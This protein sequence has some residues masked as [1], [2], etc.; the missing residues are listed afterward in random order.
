MAKSCAVI[1]AAGEGKRMKSDRPKVML[2]VLFKPMIQ[3]V[4]DSVRNSGTEDICTVVGFK[5]EIIK[6]YLGEKFT[7]VSQ[8]ERLGT[9]HAV[10]Q[11]K[12]FLADHAG[13]HV[14][15][16]C[17]DAP[18]MDSETIRVAYE[19]HISQGNAATI[20]TACLDDPTGYGRVIR[21]GI[22]GPVQRIVEHKDATDE[23]K[24]VNEINS[25]AYW[26]DID[27]LLPIL[28]IEHLHNNNAQGEYYLPEVISIFIEKK[29]RV[30]AYLTENKEAVMGANDCLQLNDLSSKARRNILEK[31]LVNGVEM[32]CSEGVIIGPD[33][34]IGSN[35]TILPGTILKG[36]TVVGHGCTVGPNS[37][38]DDCTVGDNSKVN[39]SQC[40]GSNIGNN[41]DIGPF[42]H[43]RNGCVVGD[44]VRIGDY[45]E[46]KNS[47]IGNE[48]KVAHLT[49][50]GDSKFG[51]KV[52][53]GCGCVTVNYNGQEK[54]GCV[55]GDNAFIGC[56]TNLI[57][58]V[59]V[60]EGA[61]TAA[62]TTITQDVP[63]KAL[64]IG[65]AR[66]EIKENWT[67]KK[68]K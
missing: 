17:G 11:A 14:L 52:N 43:I 6:D 28:D 40:Y 42:A 38:L 66:A 64:A 8:R 39:A 10:M 63:A 60:G 13:G 68:K 48:T 46:L 18:F 58:P 55:V 21:D 9:G 57:A 12:D 7:T 36:K 53:V 33:V 15:V 22:A 59:T 51:S 44:N 54:Q 1:L 16:L 45:V 37:L 23:E 49:Y 34:V 29:Y 4:I 61:Y 30:N 3:W 20:I 32:P 47:S 50:I 65:R 24:L 56:N 2:N 62:G 27:K 19:K 31:L 5:E 67:E 41:V 26:F 35:V 25:G